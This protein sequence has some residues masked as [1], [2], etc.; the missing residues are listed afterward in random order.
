MGSARELPWFRNH[1][2]AMKP[3]ANPIASSKRRLPPIA[4][5]AAAAATTA[6]ATGTTAAAAATTAAT[7]ATSLRFLHG[8]LTSLNVTAVELL[9][10]ALCF[11]LARH[12]DET[13]PA[14]PAGLAVHDHL[15]L[16][17][18]SDLREQIAQIELGHAVRQIPNVESAAHGILGFSFSV[19]GGAAAAVPSSI[20]VTEAR[21]TPS[22]DETAHEDRDE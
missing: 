6:A 5:A 3:D 16:G 13:E 4:P 17:D 19:I 1:H 10:R 14:R 7:A 8:D 9:D 11:S 12:L 21:R 22:C 2:P 18:L 15:R 20:P